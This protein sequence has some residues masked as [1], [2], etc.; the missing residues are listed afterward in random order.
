[1]DSNLRSI[2]DFP[3]Y[4]VNDLGE[5]WSTK[6]S[7][8]NPTG[9]FYK[10]KPYPVK[11]GH[12]FVC[13]C[14]NGKRYNKYVSR[15]VINAKAGDFVDHEN[16]IK[17]DNEVSN[18]RIATSAQNNFNTGPVNGSKS[19]FKGVFWAKDKDKW[20]ARVKANNIQYHIGYFDDEVEAAKAYNEKAKELH[21]EFA[22]LNPV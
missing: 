7:P 17:T 20:H 22:Y 19:E 14:K 8:R 12:L 15:L 11:K 21:G 4:F 16:R 10:L 9:K 6:K 1:M 2:P 5:V 3:G 13:L 18:L